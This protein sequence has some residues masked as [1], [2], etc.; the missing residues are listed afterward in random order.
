MMGSNM[1]GQLGVP[2]VTQTTGSPIL[3]MANRK[4]SQVSCGTDF[5]AAI[6]RSNGVFTWGNNQ[7]G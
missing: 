1:K 4:I 7:H 3:V 5:T 6:T 2:A